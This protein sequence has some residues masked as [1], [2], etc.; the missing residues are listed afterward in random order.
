MTE[1]KRDRFLRP[2]IT[3]ADGGKPIGYTRASS[4][5]KV[6]EDTYNL[7]QWGARMAVVG[8]VMDPSLAAQIAGIVNRHADPVTEARADLNALVDRAKDIAGA[9]KASSTGTA[10]HAMTEVLDAGETPVAVPDDLWPVLDAYQ[11]G[12][13]GVEMLESEVFVVVDEITAAG[14]LDRLVRLPDGRVVVADLKTGK[15]EPKYGNG[16]TT[17]VAVYAHGQRYDPATAERA[18]LHPDLDIT[19]GLLIHLPL[20]PVKGKQECSLYLL[21]LVAGWDRALL[22]H[23]VRANRK[24]PRLKKWS[25]A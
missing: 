10:I 3:P 17:Q 2:L 15:D 13:T 25:A 23:T 9:N 24:Q 21:D 14:T 7:T 8:A 5:G 16:V 22:A 6:L 4:F 19:T 18:P 20:Q 11:W 1:I 12:T